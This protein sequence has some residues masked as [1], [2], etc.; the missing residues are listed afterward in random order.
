[1]PRKAVLTAALARDLLD[2]AMSFRR[3]ARANLASERLALDELNHR[4]D[5]VALHRLMGV[6]SA[7]LPQD[8]CRRF[9]AESNALDDGEQHA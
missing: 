5:T 9:D 4:A 2:R 3:A 6:L 8:E 7:Y 1:M